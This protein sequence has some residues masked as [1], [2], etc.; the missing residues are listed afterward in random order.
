MPGRTSHRLIAADIALALQHLE[1]V[2]AQL[3]G[4]ASAPLS[5]CA[6][7]RRC[8]C[9]SAYPRGDRSST[10]RGSPLPARLDHAGD[11]AGRGQFAQ[12]DAR[13]L[14]LAIEGARAAGQL[15]A[16]ADARLASELRGIS[17]SFRRAA[18]RSSGGRASRRSRSPSAA[19]AWPA[20]CFAMLRAL[21]VLVD[22]TRLGHW[23]MLLPRSAWRTACRSRAAARL[24][25]VI[26]LRRGAR[27]RCPCRERHRPCRNRSRGTRAAP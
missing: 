16:V 26:G 24:R 3:R 14:E 5:L 18:K 19:R 7:L 23:S 20:N 22:G 17:A 9:G 2:G 25:L 4:R 1:H 15:A 27:S 6:A 8:G 10:Y 12:R 21:R 11:L 13:Q